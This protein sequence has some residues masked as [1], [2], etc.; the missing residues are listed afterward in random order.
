MKNRTH[1]RE[2]RH[3]VRVFEPTRRRQ[4]ASDDDRGRRA[5]RRREDVV[6]RA[7]RDRAEARGAAKRVEVRQERRRR[8]AGEVSLYIPGG[9][10]PP[11][12]SPSH[13]A[14]LLNRPIA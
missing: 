13:I 7:R 12:L 1:L 2:R 5:R 11:P 14:H 4:R 8:R 9:G 10:Y 6:G 3:G